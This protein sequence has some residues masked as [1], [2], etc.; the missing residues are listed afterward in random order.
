MSNKQTT[1]NLQGKKQKLVSP[2]SDMFKVSKPKPNYIQIQPSKS[3][4]IKQKT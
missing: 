3:Y 2:N 4:K 1:N